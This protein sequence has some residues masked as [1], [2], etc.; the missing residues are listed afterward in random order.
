MGK[1][2][3]T[4]SAAVPVAPRR[5]R[6]GREILEVRVP[7]GAP[8]GAV[9]CPGCQRTLMEAAFPLDTPQGVLVRK[10]CPC[11]RMVDVRPASNVV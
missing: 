6:R 1:A 7:L 9:R 2:I 11:C 5:D 8:L 4:G 3:Q 10:A